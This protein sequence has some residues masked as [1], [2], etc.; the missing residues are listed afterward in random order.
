MSWYEHVVGVELESHHQV[1]SQLH[2]LLCLTKCCL[3]LDKIR[4][5]ILSWLGFLSSPHYGWPQLNWILRNLSHGE[6]LHSQHSFSFLSFPIVLL[7]PYEC[8]FDA[9]L[10]PLHNGLHFTLWY[11]HSQQLNEG[12]KD[13]QRWNCLPL[14]W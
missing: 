12:S 5:E 8:Y 6:L 4:S 3:S 14:W 2:K 7:I 11:V 9:G 13:L 1:C 10:H